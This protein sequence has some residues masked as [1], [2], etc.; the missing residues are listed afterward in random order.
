MT[1]NSVSQPVLLG[2]V[3]TNDSRTVNNFNAEPY[4]NGI[5]RA[6]SKLPKQLEDT[7]KK[8]VIGS[9]LNE[10]FENAEESKNLSVE[11]TSEDKELNNVLTSQ[12]ENKKECIFTTNNQLLDIQTNEVGCM[13]NDMRISSSKDQLGPQGMSRPYGYKL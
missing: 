8:I 10:G 1:E 2:D 3:P 9:L 4:N 12:V 13:G 7:S 6:K 11:E 5:S